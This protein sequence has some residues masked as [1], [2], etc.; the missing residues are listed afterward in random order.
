VCSSDLQAVVTLT[1]K[2]G[3]TFTGVAANSF[4]HTGASETPSNAVN[5][6]TV[7]ITFPATTGTGSVTITYVGPADQ[8]IPAYAEAGNGA[9]SKDALSKSA[10]H[11]LTLSA[12]SSVTW[13]LNGTDTTGTQ[14]VINAGDK[15][16]GT[17]TVTVIATTI[18]GKRW[19]S[20][21]DFTVTE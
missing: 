7:T 6:G 1:A 2:T 15:N 4:T 19:T 14:L 21:V 16:I 9:A 5:S 3:F 18:D 8:K 20:T 10:G 11:T 17:Y 13:R 12:G